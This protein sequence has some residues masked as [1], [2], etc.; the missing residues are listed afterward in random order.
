MYFSASAVIIQEYVTEV[1]GTSILTVWFYYVN[2]F[3]SFSV[4][5]D[6]PIKCI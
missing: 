5:S 6:K 2:L 4:Q 1:N 3:T